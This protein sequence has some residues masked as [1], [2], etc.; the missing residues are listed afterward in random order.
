MT[1]LAGP[2]RTDGDYETRVRES[3]GRQAMMALIGAR[4][5]R[6]EPGLVEI[7]LPFRDVLTQQDGY[8]HAGATST[9]ADSAGGYAAYTL[10]PPG[11]AVL[12]TEFKIN[13]L[14]PAAGDRLRATGRVI[15]PGRILSVCDLEVV[16]FRG[17]DAKM[18][19][20]GLQTLICLPAEDERP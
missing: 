5:I 4:L 9:I 18:C 6:V 3:F 7:E 15:R 20:K 13:L 16:A 14:A 19:A 17:D 11:A 12:T 8:I 1:A 10:F 2:F